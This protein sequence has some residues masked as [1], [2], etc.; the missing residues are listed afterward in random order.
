MLSSHGDE[1]AGGR[2][3]RQR[4][5]RCGRLA[6]LDGVQDCSHSDAPRI[7][8]SDYHGGARERPSPEAIARSQSHLSSEPVRARPEAFKQTETVLVVGRENGAVR[9]TIPR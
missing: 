9:L 8:R 4:G 1:L 2:R 7:R 5:G 3:D 6:Q